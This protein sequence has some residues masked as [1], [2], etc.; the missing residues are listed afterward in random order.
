ME[1]L[2]RWGGHLV[3]DNFN[4]Q[5]RNVIGADNGVTIQYKKNLK[6]ITVSED[7]STVC[8]KVLP[9]GKDGF[10]L[11]ELYLYSDIQYSI[12]Y[13]KTVTFDQ[14]YI[15][16]DAYPDTDSY[17]QALRADLISQ[18]TEY[19]KVAQYPKINYTLS[20]NIDKITDEEL[21]EEKCYKL[22]TEI[23]AEELKELVRKYKEYYKEV[24][25]EDDK[26][27]IL[28]EIEYRL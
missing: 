18:A 25:K 13:T 6:E 20:A 9:V 22:D 4:L 26:F 12:P 17:K 2:N 27:K 3:R 1:M 24:S 8:T 23:S 16:E 10:L 15:E 21:K 19:L 14:T 11:D 28:F 5:I 7:W